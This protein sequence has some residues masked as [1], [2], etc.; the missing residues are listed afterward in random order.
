M[1]GESR[2]LQDL[3]RG[4]QQSGFVGRRGQVV[5]YQENLAL[6]PDDAR[7]RFLFNIHGNAGVGKT[8][9]TKQLRQ[10]AADSGALTAYSDETVDDLTS[11][12]SAIAEEFSRRG[13]RLGDFEKRVAAYRQRRHELEADPDAPDGV[14]AL[15]TRTAVTIGLHAARDIPIAGSILAPV[16]DAR[17]IDQA[18]RARMYLARKFSDHA[19]VRL[20]L[21][22][23]DE[24]TP[25]FVAGLNRIAGGRSVALFFDT[26]ERTSALLDRWLR[27]LYAGRYGDLPGTLIT[28]ISGQ[29]P[30]SANLWA[31]YLAVIADV[32]LEPFS[33]AEARQYL[34]S[35]NI[36]DGTTAEVILRLSGRLPMWLATLAEARPADAAQIGDPA[37]DSVERFLKWEADP[38]RRNVAVTAAL[39]RGLNQDVLS[40]I[41]AP[42]DARDLFEWLCRLPFVT[43]QAGSWRYHE[44]VRAAMLRLQR[45]QSPARWRANHDRLAQAHAQWA[46]DAA[47]DPEQAW[48]NQDW[49]DHT[50]EKVYHLLCGDPVGNLQL[51]LATAAEAAG[52]AASRARQW[53]AIFAD[54]GRDTGHAVLTTWGKRLSAGIHDTDLTGYLTCLIDDARLGMPAL[55]LALRERGM[56]YTGEGRYEEALADFTRALSSWIPMTFRPSSIA[57]KLAI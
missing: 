48:A 19:D 7:R 11:A 42:G 1:A 51:A 35:K 36:T 50:R 16:D 27:D 20:L 43:R 38:A 34:A 54:A 12:M 46:A 47:G 9:L 31:D 14:A 29:H 13:V 8:Y 10:V 15:L 30:L 24:L 17:L 4:R 21:S 53:A 57:G 52:S 22:P 55:A 28:T 26:Y 45:A 33:E 18:H 49:A 37:G 5:Q 32:P 2:S 56:S 23:A 40:I 3:I 44:V 25:V 39:P 6:A 41:A